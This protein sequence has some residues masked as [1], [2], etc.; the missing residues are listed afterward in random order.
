MFL[1][2]PDLSFKN[3]KRMYE[4]YTSDI[5]NES[6]KEIIFYSSCLA[7]YRLHLLVANGVVPQ[8]MRKFK[9]HLLVLARAIISGKT[10]PNLNSRAIE[11]Y[12]QKIVDAFSRPGQAA[13][14]PFQRAVEIVQ[15]IEHLT[16]DRLKRQAVLDEMLSQIVVN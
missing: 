11:S 15:S 12:C 13:V 9:W 1:E 2:R 10:I 3:P 8:N 6:N 5:F 4:E 14:D 16:N 7:L